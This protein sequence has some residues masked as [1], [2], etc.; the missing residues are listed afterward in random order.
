[1]DIKAPAFPES[2][3]EG[4]VAVWHKA[5]GEPIR[6][7]DL[8]VDIETDKVVLEVV[9][10]ADGQVTRIVKQEGDIVAS[11]ELLAVF[12][13]GAVATPEVGVAEFAPQAAEP[14]S[15]SPAARKLAEEK[16]LNIARVQGTGR[17]GR[18]TKDD[19]AQYVVE[20]R[21]TPPP[22][23][24]TS[25]A[26]AA[27]GGAAAQPQPPR[28]PAFDPEGVAER[29]ERR[30]PM[31]RLR[32]SIAR[33]LVAA[34]Q[35]AA[36]LTTFNE[37]DMSPVMALRRKYQ[38]EF[39]ARHNGT[40]LGFM[41]FFVRA[42]VEALKR[43]PAV[44]ASIDGDDIVYHGYYDIG[45]AV[46]T[47][48]GLVVPVVRDADALGM[49][50]IEDQINGYGEKARSG[51]LTIEEMS[52]GTFTLSNG[53]VFGSLLS[54]PILNPPQT[55]ILGMH[56]IQDRPVVQDGEVVARPMMYLALSYDHRLIDGSDAV[57]FLVDIKGLLEDPARI[58]LEL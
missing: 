55:G 42:S 58:L 51:K 6:R 33:R 7:D 3:I 15:A 2:I 56:K 34:Q 53:G 18:I 43:F 57:R 26:A 21:P 4:T 9:A 5:P 46:N 20:E 10:P 23:G 45:V 27:P 28:A 29:V 40:R 49:A 30:V 32:K 31:T 50:Q 36:M 47:D 54:T 44:N 17:D 25:K 14:A 12:E 24:R 1:M 35:N 11:E 22:P 38:E 19:V 8:L 41:S 16:G 13:A 48:R 39:R 52:G 37:V